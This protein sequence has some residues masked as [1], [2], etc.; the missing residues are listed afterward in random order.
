[1]FV[2]QHGL[3]QSTGNHWHQDG[4]DAT[5]R[6]ELSR[7][8]LK[9]FLGMLKDASSSHETYILN[10]SFAAASLLSTG[11]VDTDFSCKA[12]SNLVSQGQK[13]GKRLHLH[14]DGCVHPG[15]WAQLRHPGSTR[16]KRTPQI[17]T[18]L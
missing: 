8:L 16:V 9:I 5:A 17:G 10:R 6:V 13:E 18:R 12:P 7:T 11:R 4:I 2:S 3:F 1:M 14:Q 15:L